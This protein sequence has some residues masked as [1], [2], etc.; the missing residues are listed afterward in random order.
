MRQETRDTNLDWDALLSSLY[1]EIF[2]LAFTMCDSRPQAED[3]AQE[4]FLRAWR[5]Q[6]TLRD[7]TAV[8]QWLCRILRNENNRRFSRFRFEVHS[9]DILQQTSDRSH[10]PEQRA[11]AH[12]LQRAISEL[13]DAYRKPLILHAYG[14]YTGKEIAARLN[15]KDGAVSTRL[16]RARAELH[17]KF[18][19]ES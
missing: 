14:G 18:S 9:I 11:E 12:L 13:G 16:F 6:R 10:G 15:L 17:E 8:K 19:P 7:A 4:T 3:L 5:F 1:D 2:R